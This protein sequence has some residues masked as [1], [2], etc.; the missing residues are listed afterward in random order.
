[1]S[2]VPNGILSRSSNI[3]EEVREGGKEGG[4]CP[5]CGLSSGW[6]REER[7]MDALGR[8]PGPGGGK[9]VSSPRLSSVAA[10]RQ[11][12]GVSRRNV[13]SEILS[14]LLVCFVITIVD[15]L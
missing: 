8:D 3:K 15:V 9:R 13:L 10:A 14:Y 1:M 12:T 7:T 4:R 11:D 5:A 6:R 2:E